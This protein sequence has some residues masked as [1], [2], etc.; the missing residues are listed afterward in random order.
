MHPPENV[1]AFRDSMA[2]ICCCSEDLG[3]GRDRYC[4]SI[5]VEGI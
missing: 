4:I 2:G 5:D 1:V 3:E